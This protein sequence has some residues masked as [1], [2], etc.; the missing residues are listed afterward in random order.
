MKEYNHLMHLNAAFVH[1]LTMMHSL[2]LEIY[3]SVYS[4]VIK[5]SAIKRCPNRYRMWKI[6][7]S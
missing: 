5:L 7:V 3:V 2:T 1:A 6:Y 4:G